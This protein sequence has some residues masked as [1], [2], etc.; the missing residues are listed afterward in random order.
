MEPDILNLFF[1]NFLLW[2]ASPLVALWISYRSLTGR[3]LGLR[4][5]LGFLSENLVVG[6]DPVVWL[7]AVSLGEVKSAHALADEL[8]ARVPGLHIVFTTSTRTGYEEARRRAKPRDI[9]LYPPID[10]R[11]ICRRFL[12]AIRPDMV[13]ILETELWPNLFHQ[14]R[15]SGRPL[16]LVN[17]RISDRSLPRYQATRFFWRSVLT[18]PTNIYAQSPQNAARFLDL[19]AP[20]SR[21]RVSGNLKF[22]IRPPESAFVTELISKI[23]SSDV[24]PLIVAGSTMPGE[25]KM[26]LEAFQ[27]LLTRIPS[28]WLILAPRHPERFDEV[29]E[30]IQSME[31]R[32]ERRSSWTYDSL[33]VSGSV[34]L[35]DS[36]GELASVY[37]IANIVVIGGTLVPTG[38]HNLLEAAFF[39]KPII[40]GPSMENFREICEV[41]MQTNEHKSFPEIPEANVGAVLQIPGPQSLAPSIELLLSNPQ[42]SNELGDSAAELLRRN[43]VGVAPM[44]KELSSQLLNNQ[45]LT[46]KPQ[47]P[48]REFTGEA[49]GSANDTEKVWR[50]ISK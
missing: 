27:T 21:V 22:R 46:N 33:P 30:L 8:R 20:A 12:R 34:L 39:G 32:N 23:K 19:G 6:D 25:E 2:L 18:L 29:L 36:M 16:I 24:G 15:R 31:F 45:S 1:Y 13:V 5:R 14:T 11:W 9:V 26:V 17:A 43:Q 47:A 48:A 44:I 40:I 49:T 35:L 28:P 50:T 3:M 37:Q 41:F 4:Q 10:Y 7:N 38:G 42:L